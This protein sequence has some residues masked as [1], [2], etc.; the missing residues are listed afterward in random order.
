[1]E[2]GEKKGKQPRKLNGAIRRL[3][4]ESLAYWEPSK[5]SVSERRQRSTGLNTMKTDYCNLEVIGDLTGN[6]VGEARG[7]P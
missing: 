5:E 6:S 4:Q 3:Y 1:M 7:H 2:V